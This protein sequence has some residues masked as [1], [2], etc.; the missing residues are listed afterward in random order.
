MDTSQNHARST[1]IMQEG[2]SLMRRTRTIRRSLAANESQRI[3][4]DNNNFNLNFKVTEFKVFATNPA[5]ACMVVLSTDETAPTASVTD[6]R[7]FGWGFSVADQQDQW[8]D[9]PLDPNHIIVQDMWLHEL[10][11]GACEVILIIELFETTDDE[12]A[13]YMLKENAQGNP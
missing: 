12:A 13:L 2:G 11:G 10:R 4:L 1:Q 6:N 3:S 9:Q 5:T 8:D 7:Q